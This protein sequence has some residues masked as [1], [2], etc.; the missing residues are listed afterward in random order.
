MLTKNKWDGRNEAF[1]T[2][3]AN[4]SNTLVICPTLLRDHF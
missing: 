2:R 4:F 1:F 3:Q